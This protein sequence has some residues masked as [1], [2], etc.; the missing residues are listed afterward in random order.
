MMVDYMGNKE[1]HE[2]T[3]VDTVLI[4]GPLIIDDF[5]HIP[6]NEPIFVTFT[7][8]G[9]IA[10]FDNYPK[11]FIGYDRLI[12][13]H[14][15]NRRWTI[16][17]LHGQVGNIVRSFLIEANELLDDNACHKLLDLLNDN[18]ILFELKNDN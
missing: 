6:D 14:S 16:S 9:I 2:Y 15:E 1:S 18:N 13:I 10:V 4:Q 3:N 5:M 17:Y 7:E 12:N 11:K 8:R